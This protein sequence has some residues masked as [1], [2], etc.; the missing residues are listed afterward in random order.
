MHD[1]WTV[2][3][4]LWPEL[5]VA[6]V[7]GWA[8]SIVTHVL[9]VTLIVGGAALLIWAF[10][11][12]Q[13]LGPFRKP[14]PAPAPAPKAEPTEAV[15]RDAT[16]LANLLAAQMDRQAGRLEQLINEAD[17]RIR[18][19]ERLAATAEAV[20]ARPPTRP[21]ATDPLNRQIYALADDGMPTV[22]IARQ[23]QQQTGKVELILALRQR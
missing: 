3:P 18:R 13:G 23:L 5:L 10:W 20:A 22:E 1:T 21:D 19:L 6:D 11:R 2:Q 4:P 14:P 9:P 16:E 12:G 8:A 15:L 17:A 7:S